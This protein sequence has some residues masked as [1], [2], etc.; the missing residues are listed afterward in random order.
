MIFG[1]V[2]S[3]DSWHEHL[4]ERFW[5]ELYGAMEAFR[6]I[7]TENFNELLAV[8]T[9]NKLLDSSSSFKN[10]EVQK[11]KK[12][13]WNSSLKLKT[14]TNYPTPRFENCSAMK[15]PVRNTNHVMAAWKVMSGRNSNQIMWWIW[16]LNFTDWNW[17]TMKMVI[18]FEIQT[19]NRTT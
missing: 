4:H 7:Q 10:L 2:I 15:L 16:N 17:F 11:L 18:L 3:Q 8:D 12:V 13:Y 19:T 1:Q 6:E 14:S 9:L 5:W